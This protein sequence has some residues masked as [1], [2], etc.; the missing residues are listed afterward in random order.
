MNTH[1][2]IYETPITDCIHLDT[3]FMLAGTEMTTSEDYGYQ[4][5]K[6]D[7]SGQGSGTGGSQ[8][9]GELDPGGGFDFPPASA[10]SWRDYSFDNNFD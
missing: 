6:S 5:D 8:T 3:P 1:K 7:N 2:S 9:G 4:H 10:K